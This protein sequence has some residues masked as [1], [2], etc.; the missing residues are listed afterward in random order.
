MKINAKGVICGEGEQDILP[1]VVQDQDQSQEQDHNHDQDREEDQHQDQGQDQ[2]QNQNLQVFLHA[3][4]IHRNQREHLYK[5][6][7]NMLSN[8]YF[9]RLSH[10]LPRRKTAG[11]SKILPSLHNYAYHPAIMHDAYHLALKRQ[12][13][14]KWINQ[15]I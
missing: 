2:E 8:N 11:K 6:K 1:A 13:H 7:I 9:F 10:H 3:C 12:K 4:N 14:Y 15:K 5:Y